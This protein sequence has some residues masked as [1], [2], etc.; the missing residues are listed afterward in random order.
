MVRLY[1]VYFAAL[2]LPALSKPLYNSARD[3]LDKSLN[4]GGDGVSAED[5]ERFMTHDTSTNAFFTLIQLVLFVF[6]VSE[7][8]ARV[9]RVHELP[10]L[11]AYQ[12]ASVLMAS[13]PMVKPISV[14]MWAVF[15][16]LG[17]FSYWL[18]SRDQMPKQQTGIPAGAPPLDPNVLTL[19]L[20]AI[21]SAAFMVKSFRM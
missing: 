9:G 13:A 21:G 17:Q 3:T 5:I 1:F 2:I 4:M 12:C 10:M 15:M 6:A 11:K 14:P 8:L 19:F 18:L 20:M 7:H 16:Q